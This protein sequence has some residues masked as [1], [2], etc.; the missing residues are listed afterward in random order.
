MAIETQTTVSVTCISNAV[1]D[2]HL[3]RLSGGALAC[4]LYLHRAEEDPDAEELARG[5]GYNALNVGVF[6]R[7]LIMR[8]LADSRITLP[9]NRE[10]F[11]LT[12]EVE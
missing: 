2:E 10:V 1:L 11:W 8:G 5:T 9:G 3:P 7:E 4:L 6:M 12:T